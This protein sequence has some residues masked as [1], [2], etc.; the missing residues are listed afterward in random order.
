LLEKLNIALPN[1]L[2]YHCAYT[3]NYGLN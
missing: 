1:I 3:K 2:I